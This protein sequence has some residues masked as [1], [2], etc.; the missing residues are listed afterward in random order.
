MLAA[1]LAAASLG[2]T[3]IASA[4][5]PGTLSVYAGTGVLTNSSFSPGDPCANGALSCSALSANFLEPEGIATNSAGDLFV[6]DTSNELVYEITPNGT[7]SFVAGDVGG[8]LPP[9]SPTMCTSDASGSTN[10][11]CLASNVSPAFPEGVAVNNSGDLF[12]TDGGNGT[13]DEENLA[14]GHIWVIAG[15][16]AA[17]GSGPCG[18]MPGALIQSCAASSAHLTFPDSIGVDDATGD[19]YFSDSGTFTVDEVT[20]SGQLSVFAGNGVEPSNSATNNIGSLCISAAG[21]TC[22]ANA[23]NNALKSFSVNVDQANGDVLIGDVSS[24]QVLEVTPSGVESAIAGCFA[25]CTQPTQNGTALDQQIGIVGE[26]QV[27]SAG[28][29]FV[30]TYTLNTPPGQDDDDV[31]EITPSGQLSLVAGESGNTGSP[32]PGP[33][34]NSPFEQPLGIAFDPAGNL[35]I[36]DTNA[37]EIL[38]ETF[39]APAGPPTAAGPSSVSFGVA[40]VGRSSAA[41]TVT[42]VNQGGQNLTVANVTLGSDQFGV[43]AGDSSDFSISADKCSGA[44]IAPGASC[45]LQV[46]FTPTTSGSRSSTLVI[47]SNDPNSPLAVQL[48]GTAVAAAATTTTTTTSTP[49]PATTKTANSTKHSTDGDQRVTLTTP[50]T[51]QC[52]APTAK[53]AASLKSVK[54]KK[55][56]KLTFAGAKFYIDKDKTAA[57]STKHASSTDRLSVAKLKAGSHT[58]KV[59]ISFKET[60]TEKM[61]KHGKEV[62]VKKTELVTKT[63]DAK[64]TVC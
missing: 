21:Q 59:V 53:L 51:K 63:M 17:N 41:Q 5:E 64:F 28:D 3:S 20:P 12:I 7:L 32:V 36:A 33:A 25:V 1:A 43:S 58:L 39:A 57:G 45:T 37:D 49:P 35:F 9:V 52:L 8:T 23:N 60:K 61:K 38:K 14:D 55:G 26:M 6:P 48:S 19:V 10:P 44:T 62:D 56:T 42:V 24:G 54:S 11:N 18:G 13:I 16:G 46:T 40:T 50:S 15:G 2:F 22:Q 30:G 27:D 31:V 4:A 29:V 47:P 34:L